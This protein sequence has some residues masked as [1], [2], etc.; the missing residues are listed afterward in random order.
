MVPNHPKAI[1]V[2]VLGIVSLGIS[3]LG[4]ISGMV[5]DGVCC[6]I[7]GLAGIVLGAIALFFGI[8]AKREIASSGGRYGG[9]G[10]TMAGLICGGIGL[11]LGILNII[12][13]ILIWVFILSMIGAMGGY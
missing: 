1:T 13:G 8:K 12:G 10:Y 4:L 11:G 9:H 7:M 5:T 3:F 2:M 6:F